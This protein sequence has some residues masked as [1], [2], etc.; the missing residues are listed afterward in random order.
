MRSSVRLSDGLGGGRWPEGAGK[1]SE[2]VRQAYRASHGVVAQRLTCARAWRLTDLS[3]GGQKRAGQRRL[4]RVMGSRGENLQTRTQPV[5]P[6]TPGAG[7][8]LKGGPPP[9]L[10]H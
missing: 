2:A 4:R 8:A 10:H 3:V 7:E 5:A 1:R 6:S 9:G